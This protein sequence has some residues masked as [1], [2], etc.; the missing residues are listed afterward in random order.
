MSVDRRPDGGPVSE[1]FLFP[2]SR[3]QYQLFFVQNLLGTAP[4][5][6]VALRHLVRGPLDRRALRAALQLLLTRH[7]ALRTHF[8]LADGQ[9]FQVVREDAALDYLETDD[10]APAWLDDRDREPFDLE[11]GPL[12]RA[13]LQNL[14]AD[15]SVLSLAM[16]H[17]V[18]DGWSAGILLDELIVAYRA[19]ATGAEPD[20]PVPEFQYADYSGWQDEW[21]RGAAAAR[22]LDYWRT[23][24]AGDLPVLRL[25]SDTA[26]PP[27][28]AG[29][30]IAFPL[31]DDQIGVLRQVARDADGTLFLVLLAAF[32]VLLR[33]QTGFDDI[34]VGTAA[35]NRG[36]REFHRT[37]GF[38]VNT[39]ALRADLGG[40]PTFRELVEQVRRTALAAYDNQEVPFDLVVTALN[41]DR[42]P[43]HDPVLQV[44]CTLNEAT[45]APV[46]A[47]GARFEPA[48]LR[49]ETAKYPFSLAITDEGAAVNAE[50]DYR[51]G[52]FSTER[53]ELFAERY[54]AILA[55]ASAD[56]D[57]PVSRLIGA[58][59]PVRAP[60]A[61][62]AEDDWDE[63]VPYAPPTSR[64]EAVL[65]EIFAEVLGR[66]RVGIDDNYF[67]LG[68]DSIRSVRVLA[69]TRAAGLR[70]R[71]T[72]LILHQTI[73]EIAPLAV[74]VDPE[75]T[76]GAEPFTL[77]SA[78]DRDL[79]GAGVQD[80]YP[81]LGVQ[82]GMVFHSEATGEN[83]LYHNVAT[84]LLRTEHSTGA[85]ERAV[86]RLTRRHEV[87]RTSFSLGGFSTPLQLVHRE[88]PPPITVEDLRDLPE[89]ATRAAVDARFRWERTHPFD[90][91][92][93]PLIRFHVQRCTE[94]TAQLWVVEHHAIMDG[95][96]GRSL[97]AELLNTYLDELGRP[98]DIPPAPTARFRAAVE[99]ERAAVADTA[100]REFWAEQ[101]RDLTTTGPPRTGT[102]P[103][104]MRMAEFALPA[105][106]SDGVAELAKA[107]RVPVRI[108]L[109]AAHLRV[110]GLLGGGPDVVTGAVY[111]VRGEEVDSDRVVGLFLNTV[112]FRCSLT[113]GTWRELV[114]RVAAVDLAIQPHR[115]YPL[116]QVQREH[117]GGPLFET[118]FNYTH[119]HVSRTQPTAE[120]DLEVVAEDGVVP[121]NFPFGAEFFQELGAESIGLALRYDA[122]LRTDDEV[123]RIHGYY[124]A[125]LTALVETPDEP[126]AEAVLL[127][128]DEL[129]ALAGWNATE[130]AY[131]ATHVLH[132]LARERA[133]AVPDLPA[134]IHE[135][136]TLT[137]AQLHESAN[138]VAHRLI[139]LGARPGRFIGVTA[140]RSVEL[141]VGLL[142]VLKAG[143]AYVPLDPD[144]PRARLAALAQ[145]AGVELVLVGPGLHVDGVSTEPLDLDAVGHLPTTAPEVVV[146]PEAPAYLIHTS[147]STGKPKGVAVSH[148]AICNRLLWMQ[149]AYPIG[150]DDVL[151]QKTPFSFDVSLWEFFWPMIT[152]ARLVV[153]RPG[154]HR[155][156]AHLTDLIQ[157]H[158][159]TVIHFVPSML[160]AFLADDGLTGCASLHRVFCSGEALPFDLQQD[161][162]AHHTADLVNLYGPTEAAVDVSH[163]RC[164][165]GVERVVPI[166]H[167]IA[168]TALH[169]LDH[170][171]NPVPVGVAGELCVGGTGLAIGYPSDPDLTAHRFP[172]TRHGRVY[173]TGDLARRRPDGA[174]EFLGRL[175]DQVKIRGLRVEPG[176]VE[177]ALRE[178][179]TVRDCAVLVRGDTLVACVV[180][181]PALDSAAL[182]ACLAERLPEH[183]IPGLWIPVTAI[184]LSANGKTDRRALAEL[185]AR[186]RVPAP[187]DTRVAPR[188][189]VE[190]EL[191]AMWEEVLGV[192]P[193]SVEDTFA[194]LG[195]H[196][197]AAL[198]VIAA[199]R[200]R[201][202]RS[203]SPADLLGGRTVA[204]LAAKLGDSGVGGGGVGGG[205]V[206]RDDAAEL[207]VLRAGG[208]LDPVVLIHPSDGG[209]FCYE[210]L[211]A[212][213][214]PRHPVLGIAA[215]GLHTGA[216]PEDVP[217]MAA[218][219]LALLR[220]DRATGTRLLVGWSF[221]GVVAHELARQLTAA[222]ERV[223]LLC[224]VDSAFPGQYDHSGE[225][226]AELL[227]A[228]LTGPEPHD[229]SAL[230]A[231][232]RRNLA[233]QAAH[234]PG[235]Y[236]GDAVFVQGDH[237]G[238]HG[239][240]DL[241]RPVIGG[242]LTVHETG[243]DHKDLVAPPGVDVLADLVN[244]ALDGGAGR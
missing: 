237:H 186:E 149:D 104:D 123:A 194:D 26:E 2:A 234:R 71:L 166:G 60:R 129:R 185:V 201:F 31:P 112:P 221:G 184:P 17:I 59:A 189:E 7:E 36:R 106:V 4:T 100:Q 101:V 118:F 49:T 98:K 64:T 169:V 120:D 88:V 178:H 181:D 195:G 58:P 142:A 93:A 87:L 227:R 143:C 121:T 65:A 216:G 18:V 74:A 43:E 19:I 22:Q 61:A 85:W 15:R 48:E 92:R 91:G 211:A 47:A 29:S 37:V 1:E 12:F 144:H 203:L 158:G 163:W 214:D 174:L 152:G 200:G 80:A 208:D 6:H 54:L 204:A 228:D 183:L 96:S 188:T 14:A 217:A 81:L 205:G 70:V 197:L 244:R 114:A 146:A 145:D 240:A 50:L 8:T 154:G 182:R 126:H 77:I 97:F 24:L 138:Q 209:V 155:D 23:A 212:R 137:H 68:G 67:E 86:R 220:A 115:R 243:I 170:D 51:T 135:R 134:V 136:T 193:I 173:R 3:A 236:P 108:V 239:S 99:A 162:L 16:H 21:L 42:G 233:A 206:G 27:S 156:P 176:E 175:D 72:D 34:V 148:R 102:A 226:P 139:E 196:S 35:A 232:L 116:A 222:G 10:P 117:G 110:M 33:E 164:R 75:P 151:V 53:V 41:P 5:Y 131:S 84:Y 177:A 62:P 56:P 78:A 125:A 147:G 38:F 179:G 180:A 52:L 32:T 161:F 224:L 190:R 113:G 171:L 119:F 153:A 69:H 130:R 76:A 207:L 202:D 242:R 231:V 82:A 160:R 25:P 199:V 63:P 159:V 241:W 13:R 124:V 140:H 127:S 132:E 73:R 30:S 210:A 165:D 213:V 103:A 215:A 9:L 172:T 150:R 40:D 94:D 219:Y 28:S 39:V 90:L 168:N 20:L 44:L 79:V 167:P 95:W 122:N 235:T 45:A 238:D 157:R 105:R 107:A 57:V 128:A 46:E 11:R 191:A 66:D 109:L 218:D 230:V 198:R 133:A 83:Q 111:N 229:W 141:V 187:V 192:G 55:G 223:G 225:D 89:D